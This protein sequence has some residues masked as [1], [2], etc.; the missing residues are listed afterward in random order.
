MNKKDKLYT[1]WKENIDIPLYRTIA[2]R[3]LNSIMQHG[4]NPK[5][6]PYKKIRK[7]LLILFKLVKSLEKEGLIM[8]FG[9]GKRSSLG[10]Y[11]AE[12]ASHE[13]KRDMIDF[14][15]VKDH[16]SYYKELK[17]GAMVTCVKRITDRIIEEKPNL[18][19][20]QRHLVHELNYWAKKSSCKMKSIMIRGSLKNLKNAHFQLTGTTKGKIRKIHKVIY[21]ESPFGDFKHFLRV[22]KKNKLIKYSHRLRNRKY[23]LRVRMAIPK[24]EITLIN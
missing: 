8:K 15:P 7:K 16:F 10:S 22:I 17:G 12:M 9:I 5:N 20:K 6:N 21:Y 24:N 3:D 19:K 11:Y 23:Y 4:L 14:T 18:T 1:F 13:L 2:V